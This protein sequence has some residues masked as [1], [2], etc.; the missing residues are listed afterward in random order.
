MTSIVG[1]HL[2]VVPADPEVWEVDPF[3]MVITIFLKFFTYVLATLPDH[4]LS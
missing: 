3:K 4:F 1:S 2:D